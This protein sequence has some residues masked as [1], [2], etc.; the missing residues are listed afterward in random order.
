MKLKK[1]KVSFKDKRGSIS[2]IFYNENIQ[3]V[4]IIKSKPNVLRGNHFHKKTTLSVV[5]KIC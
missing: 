3:H 1:L 5:S 4:A 2:D